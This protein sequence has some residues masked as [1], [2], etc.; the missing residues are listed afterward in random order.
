MIA[1]CLSTHHV[2]YD[3]VIHNHKLYAESIDLEYHYYN[4]P[5][6]VEKYVPN[7]VQLFCKDNNIFSNPFNYTIVKPFG[8]A[9]LYI[10]PDVFVYTK[11]DLTMYAYKGNIAMRGWDI[12]SKSQLRQKWNDVYNIMQPIQNRR[13]FN[14]GVIASSEE[15]VKRVSDSETYINFF[16]SKLKIMKDMGHLED[17]K[18]TYLSDEMYYS[19]LHHIDPVVRT[20]LP[21]K[22]NLF[23]HK[24]I[25][26][27]NM[28]ELYK[29]AQ[30]NVIHFT[31]YKEKLREYCEWL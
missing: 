25:P 27:Q 23:A 7:S 12:K 19:Y 29:A 22:Y 10:D 3:K 18:T 16:E 20:E 21:R 30:G 26:H 5:D 9:G 13:W 6:F 15:G 8:P 31:K 1:Y 4:A 28:G 11:E 24:D 14:C 2:Y 17:M